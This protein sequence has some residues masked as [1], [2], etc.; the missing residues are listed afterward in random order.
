[1][2]VLLLACVCDPGLK[3]LDQLFPGPG[4]EKGWSW[5]GV[6]RHFT[7]QNLYEYIDGEAELYYAYGFRELATLTYFWK[8]PEDTFFTVNVYDMGDSL[9]AFGIYSNYR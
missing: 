7:V 3:G 2:G 5:Q 9:N 8:N 6:P 1:M 4:F